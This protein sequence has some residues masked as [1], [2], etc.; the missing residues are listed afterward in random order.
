MRLERLV[1]QGF[2][3]FADRLEFVF[4]PGITAIVGPNGSGKSNVVDAIRWALGEQSLHALRGER[5]EDIIFSGSRYRRP[6]GLAEVNLTFNNESGLLPVEYSEVTVTRRAY[7]SGNSEFLLNGVSCRL[8]DIQ[9]LFADTGIG[10]DGYA[11]IGQGK[12][13]EVLNLSPQ[14]RRIFLEQA[15]GAWKWRRRKQEAQNK[16]ARTEQ[17]LIRLYD[18]CA[19]LERQR[20][21][22]VKEAHRAQEYRTKSR[23]LRELQIFVGLSE[24]RRLGEKIAAVKERIA[25][26]KQQL[27]ELGHRRST[28]EMELEQRRTGISEQEEYLE[29]LKN[30]EKELHQQVAALEKHLTS[31]WA[32][33]R[34]RAVRKEGILA[35]D[36]E[37]AQRCAE[38]EK[39]H[40]QAREELMAL[41]AVLTTKEGELAQRTEQLRDL[42]LELEEMLGTLDQRRERTIDYL[43]ERSAKSNALRSLAREE[44]ALKE[45]RERAVAAAEEAQARSAAMKQ[46]QSIEEQK[47]RS[48]EDKRRSMETDYAQLEEQLATASGQV[49]KA[50]QACDVIWRRLERSKAELSGLQSIQRSFSS[51]YQGPRS[52]LTAKRGGIIGAVAQLLTVPVEYETAIETALGAA[53]QFLVAES[54]ESAAAAID[55]L[56]NTGGGRATFLPLNTIRPQAPSPKEREVAKAGRIVGWASELAQYPKAIAPAVRNLLGRV[57]IARD[58]SAARAAAK[59]GSF[60][61]KVVTLDGD[62]VNPGG[63]LSGGSLKGRR[64]SQLSQARR[65]RE[66][67][68]IVSQEETE[69][70]SQQEIVEQT[71]EKERQLQEQL[72]QLSDNIRQA[73]EELAVASAKR[74]EY[75][76]QRTETLHNQTVWEQEER[77][78]TAKLQELATEKEQQLKAEQEAEKNLRQWETMAAE[79]DRQQQ[80]LTRRVEKI[81]KE[82]LALRLELAAV[83]EK[84]KQLKLRVEEQSIALKK[85]KQQQ[86][87]VLGQL[88]EIAKL[89]A[90]AIKEQKAMNTKMTTVSAKLE[91]VEAQVQ[92]IDEEIHALRRSLQEEDRKLIQLRQQEEERRGKVHALELSLGRLETAYQGAQQRLFETQGVPHDYEIPDLGLKLTEAKSEIDRLGQEIMALGEVNLK[93]PQTLAEINERYE[94][95]AVQ[96]KDV[97]AAKTSLVDLIGDIDQ[98][99]SSRL[100]ETFEHLRDNFRDIF[101]HLFE[102][103]QADLKLIGDDP[104]EAGLEIFAQLPGKKMQPLMLL[105]GGER[106]LTAIAF[107]FALLQCGQSSLC[108]LDEIDAPLD[109][110][111]AERFLRYLE[112]LAQ[113]TQFILVT[114]KR[115]AMIRAQALYGLAIAPNGVSSLVSV[116]LTQAAG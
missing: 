50:Q 43:S 90:T 17:D 66:L 94:F 41:T 107:L 9:D 16:L 62:V 53:Q 49:K 91:Q 58:L 93:A 72:V 73:Q 89:N 56:R 55:W 104:N 77:N 114:H 45:R 47:I 44:Q 24:M 92:E 8:R 18:V 59:A 74:Q 64:P 52:V 51:Y 31:L 14:Q 36:R 10:K 38:L 12:V 7:R 61:F 83:Q 57:L 13:D 111:N 22:L 106:A 27:L 76:A 35:Q 33:A 97:E 26:E 39:Q 63:S 82:V 102:G 34:E 65:L 80:D 37:L 40:S 75:I 71:E 101:R 100:L 46:L 85:L 95:L 103:G 3:S 67:R 28:L 15:A 79:Q 113:E 110:A 96:A 4:E 112:E 23:R 48:W 78:L 86:E 81:K 20:E 70:I 11:F 84:E 108:V 115:Q 116:D 29:K 25:P 1:V 98:T 32:E 5:L 19:E 87:G 60:R 69:L 2:K 42:E 30:Q 105:S 68:E 88:E 6:H 109:E 99:V 54:D 21:P